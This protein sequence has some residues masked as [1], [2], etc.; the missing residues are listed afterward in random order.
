MLRDLNIND[1]RAV[2]NQV[3]S[4]LSTHSNTLAVLK[5]LGNSG[6]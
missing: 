2:A 4:E 6:T 1:N 3:I 5:L